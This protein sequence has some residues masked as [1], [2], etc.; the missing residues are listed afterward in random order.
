MNLEA[1]RDLLKT[2]V[3]YYLNKKIL[4]IFE[5]SSVGR[6]GKQDRKFSI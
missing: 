5:R 3:K 2:S 1:I 4:L 6:N